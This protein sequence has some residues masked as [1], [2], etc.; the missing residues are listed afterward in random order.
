MQKFPEVV[1]HELTHVFTNLITYGNHPGWLHEG[2]AQYEA[3]QWDRIKESVLRKALLERTL[4]RLDALNRPFSEFKNPEITTLAYAESYAAVKFILERYGR[5]R[6][7][8][9]LKA[10]SAGKNFDQAAV[11]AFGLDAKTFENRWLEFLKQSY[12]A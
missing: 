9:A 6:L 12:G 8:Q 7:L 10:F 3:G 11:G 5:E 2:L 4:L 1:T